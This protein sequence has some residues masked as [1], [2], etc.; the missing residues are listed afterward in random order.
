MTG[1][2]LLPQREVFRVFRLPEAAFLSA[3]SQV[4]LCGAVRLYAVLQEEVETAEPLFR[5]QMF[6]Q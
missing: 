3:P 2:G 6:H 1:M 4:A 5:L